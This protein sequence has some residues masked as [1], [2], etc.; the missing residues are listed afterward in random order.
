MSSAFESNEFATGEFSSGEFSSD[1][2]GS[3]YNG[4]NFD[5]GG[6]DN[7]LGGSGFKTSS[8]KDNILPYKA[9]IEKQAGNTS[10]ISLMPLPRGFGLTL[11]NS[12]RR[13][14][15]SSIR[16]SAVSAVRFE[17]VMHGFATL[18]K[19]RED[20]PII[21]SNLKKLVLRTHSDRAYHIHVS[22][23]GPCVVTGAD[24][25]G[26][27]VDILNPDQYICSVSSEGMLNMECVITSGTGYVP[28]EKIK[29]HDN[30]VGMIYCD[31]LYNP[32][33]RV[34][35]EIENA[36][37]GHGTSFEKLVLTIETDGSI[38]GREAL[39]SAASILDKHL[40]ALM[41]LEHVSVESPKKEQD[42]PFDP[43]LLLH[44]NSLGLS[45]RART[46]IQS[47]NIAYLGDL[48]VLTEADLLKVKKVGKTSVNEIKNALAKY[49]LK[50]GMIVSGWPAKDMDALAA[51]YVSGDK[52]KENVEDKSDKLY[53]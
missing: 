26:Q 2:N 1:Y 47:K 42:L 52:L 33:V 29:A 48:V 4:G 25:V 9:K 35:Y 18:S 6:L 3:D 16:G 36:R 5:K 10:V 45:G 27:G 8:W 24:L 32:I 12:L 19:V 17:G 30:S 21:I 22:K 50:L 53:I 15:L 44:V 23:T 40:K 51:K 28:E 38:G 41:M 31:A 7:L 49:D 37:V 34:A 11:G 39:S 46:C 13:V 14:L 20:I 43:K